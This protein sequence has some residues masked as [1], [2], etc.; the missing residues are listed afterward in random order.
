M[1]TKS[2]HHNALKTHCVK[3]HAFTREN[4][5][6]RKDGSRACRVCHRARVAAYKRRRTVS[7][8]STVRVISNSRS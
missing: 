6:Y 7:S 5:I 3:G 8:V 2:T 1:E 4:T